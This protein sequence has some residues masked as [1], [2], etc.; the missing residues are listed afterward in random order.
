MLKMNFSVCRTH[1]EMPGYYHA[2]HAGQ[3][4]GV[5]R[6][7]ASAASRIVKGGHILMSGYDMTCPTSV[8][9]GPDC[10]QAPW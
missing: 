2:V 3:D 1:G 9:S 6:Q 7:K 4:Q 5:I 8:F 10:M